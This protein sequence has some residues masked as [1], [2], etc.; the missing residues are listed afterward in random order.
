MPAT[1]LIEI[2]NV[3]C[4]RGGTT[5]VFDNLSLTVDHGESVAVLG[6]NGAGKTTLLKLLTRDIYPVVKDDSFVKI[7]GS[8]R[9]SI[10]ELRRHIGVVSQDLQERYT[11]YSSGREVVLSGLFGAI[12]M[13]PHLL[14]TEE[15]AALTD[16]LMKEL[17]L[18]DLADK[19][20]QHL[21]T[22]QQRRLLLARAIIHQ[23]DTF[24]MDEPTNSLDIS[25]AFTLIKM[26]RNLIRQGKAVL[27]A[28]HHVE[29]ILPEIQRVVMIKKGKVVADGPK[30]ELFTSARL[31]DL[32]DTHLSVLEQNGFYHVAPVD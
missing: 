19:M 11:A 14:V 17:G 25:A 30:T 9:I 2:R 13:H 26:L 3:S 4:F 24:I 21:S 27:L 8:E 16:R 28:T 12:G 22:G 6:P 10:N 5:Q 1:P 23:P 32:Y 15:H 29:E 31:S 7:N 20:F 18:A